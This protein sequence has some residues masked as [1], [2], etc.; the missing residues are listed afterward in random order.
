MLFGWDIGSIGGILVMP[1]FMAEYGLSRSQ[2]VSS[3]QQ[4]FSIVGLSSNITRKQQRKG[5]CQFVE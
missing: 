2:E 5:K 4:K 1:T 3:M